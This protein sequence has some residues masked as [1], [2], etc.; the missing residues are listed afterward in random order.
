M[1]HNAEHHAGRYRVNWRWLRHRAVFWKCRHTWFVGDRATGAKACRKC[2]VW[3]WWPV[4]TRGT[5]P[6]VGAGS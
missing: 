3:R 4:I 2:G 5:P 1:T 6:Q